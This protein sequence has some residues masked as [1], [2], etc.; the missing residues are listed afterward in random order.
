MDW[1]SQ[2]LYMSLLFQEQMRPGTTGFLKVLDW[3]LS[4]KFVQCTAKLALNTF[5]LKNM[6]YSVS[7]QLL[8]CQ[9]KK[10]LSTYLL[11]FI[12]LFFFQL[13]HLAVVPGA[14]FQGREGCGGE[15]EVV[16]LFAEGRVMPHI[17]LDVA[18]GHAD[19]DYGEGIFGMA[20]HEG[21]QAGEKPR[22][23]VGGAFEACPAAARAVQTHPPGV[24]ALAPCYVQR[25]GIDEMKQA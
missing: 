23:K 7:T 3:L 25:P 16:V 11:C 17:A 18:L 8:F 2:P 24:A 9:A 13:L 22:E 5:I 21:L 6:R 14:V 4:K 10:Q 20:H 1:V 15:F 19:P 12:M